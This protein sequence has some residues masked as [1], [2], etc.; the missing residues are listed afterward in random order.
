MI[1]MNNVLKRGRTVWDRSLL[2]DDEYVSRV[3]VARA[4]LAATGLDG[5]VAIGHAAHYGNLTYLSGNVPPLGWMAV[6]AGREGDVV[7]VTGGGSRDLPFLSTQTW[8]DDIRPSTSLFAGPAAAVAAAVLDV[9]GAAGRV[10]LVGARDA[11]GADAQAELVRALAGYEV[12]E[13]DELLA[14]LR[15]AKRP[16][17][18]IAL[19]QSLDVARAAVAA[20][21][22]A[23]E[24]GGPGA[25][26][27]LAAER[28]ARLRGARD[29]RVLGT[30]DGLCLAPVEEFS[31]SRANGLVIACAVERLSYWSLAVGDTRDGDGAPAPARRAVDAMAAV[32]APGVPAGQLA[33]AACAEL[34]GGE[35]DI[36]LSYGLGGGV[37]LDPDERPVVRL[38]SDEP[39]PDGAVL[40]LRV[41]TRTGDVLRGAA[42]TVRVTGAGAAEL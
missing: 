7:L 29:V 27:L 17:E 32:A 2:P 39:V 25:E 24:A 11:L 4:Q 23:W 16:R 33:A 22:E 26:A 5:L 21:T 40:A 35:A 9:V 13:A 10:G 28:L 37:G 3:A 12:R 15:A 30:L 19:A 31:G 6:V 8:I 38:G 41:F 42:T 18:Q 1:T 36:A 34:P 20:A 14:P